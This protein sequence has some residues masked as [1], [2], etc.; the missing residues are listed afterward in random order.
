[1]REGKGH[2]DSVT[3]LK[4]QTI[5]SPQR[6]VI[7]LDSSYHSGANIA[8]VEVDSFVRLSVLV[9]TA[10]TTVTSTVD[11]AMVIEKKIVKPSLFSVDSTS[12]GGTDLAMGGFTNP[13]GSDFLVGGI[14]TII[15]LDTDIQNMYMSLSVEVRMR[16]EYNIKEKMRLTSVVKEK[17]QLLKAKDEEIK[18]FKSQLLL[19]DAEAAE[20]TC[21]RVEASN[22]KV[23]EKSFLDVVNALNVC[24]TILKKEHNALDVKVMDLEA[25]VLLIYLLPHDCRYMSYRF[26]PPKVKKLSNY[27]NL[28]EQ[29]EDFQ[30]AQLKVVNDKFYK[31]YTNFVEMTLHLEERF[32][33]HLL[34]TIARCRWLLTHGMELANGKCLNYPKYLSALRVAISKAIEKGMQD[35]LAAGI[36]HGREGR[37]FTDVAAHNPSTEADYVS[38][39]QQ[40][41]SVNFPLLVELKMNKDASIEDLMNILRLEEHLAERLGLNE[42]QPHANHLMRIWDDIMN[43]RSA[44]SDIF[45]SLAKPFSA[46]VLI[47]TKGTKS[48]S[49]TLASASIITPISVDDYEA[50]SINDQAAANGV[51]LRRALTPS[52]M[53]M[54]W[55]WLSLNDS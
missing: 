26:L 45:T 5:S 15:S 13:S 9:I 53:L 8:K 47:G 6:F 31:L 1:M 54:T 17:N 46:K 27:E 32:Y 33:L 28:T 24:N 7:S 29:L 52:L 55:S 51:L 23:M 42:S 16:D 18:N 4:L 19:K 21:L 11:L 2:T 48:F 30:D 38:A 43:H 40:L 49:I 36:T 35:G 41:Q 12:A 10:A 20:A 34:T 3:R 14:R 39:L 22:F 25:A 50:T 44:L 37:A